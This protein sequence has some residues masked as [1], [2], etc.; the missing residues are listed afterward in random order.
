MPRLTGC[1]RKISAFL[2]PVARLSL[3]KTVAFIVGYVPAFAPQRP[4]ALTQPRGNSPL[5]V[6]V[7]LSANN[8]LPLVPFRPSPPICRGAFGIQM[9]E[10]KGRVEGK[11]TMQ[12]L[13]YF[14]PPLIDALLPKAPHPPISPFLPGLLVDAT[15]SS[16]SW[17][18]STPEGAPVSR[19]RACCVLG[20][21]IASRID[22]SPV[23][24]ITQRSSP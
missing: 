11:P 9:Q 16:L 14:S 18:L 22:S 8:V 21:A 13:P 10:W 24:N 3:T 4:S 19:Q 15:C 17:L 1:D 12:D 23:S 7:A 2:P 6:L 20:K 5:R